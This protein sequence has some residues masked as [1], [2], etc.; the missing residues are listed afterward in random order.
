VQGIWQAAEAVDGAYKVVLQTIR[1]QYRGIHINSIRG[2][3]LGA[4]SS[5]FLRA[6]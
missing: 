6:S 1:N 4:I 5:C 2:D 3:A